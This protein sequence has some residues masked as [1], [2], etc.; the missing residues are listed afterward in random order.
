MFGLYFCLWLRE[1]QLLCHFRVS[2]NLCPKLRWIPASAGM[3]THTEPSHNAPWPNNQIP[4]LLPALT[5]TQILQ[6]YCTS[7]PDSA[8]A[9]AD[10]RQ[11][12]GLKHRVYIL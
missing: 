5:T 11:T 9:P 6:T 4:I 7:H 8:C 10:T 12:C 3:T 2:G 1:V